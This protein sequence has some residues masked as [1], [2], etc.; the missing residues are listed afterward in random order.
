[1]ASF[2]RQIFPTVALSYIKYLGRNKTIM[3]K[4]LVLKFPIREGRNLN[5]KP[6]K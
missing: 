4:Y 6:T 2:R 1:M 5:M 3:I